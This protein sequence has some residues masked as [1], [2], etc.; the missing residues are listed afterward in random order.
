MNG[1]KSLSLFMKVL[2]FLLCMRH[3]APLG[4]RN[5][6]PTL[7]YVHLQAGSNARIL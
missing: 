4:E 5:P 3:S 1:I 7:L 6:A 2:F